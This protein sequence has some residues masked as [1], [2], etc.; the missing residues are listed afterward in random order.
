ML[1]VRGFDSGV[2]GSHVLLEDQRIGEVASA[3]R[4]AKRRRGTGRLSPMDAH[5]RLQIPLRRKRPTAELAT[6]RSL[7]GVGPVVHLKGATATEDPMADC[8]FVGVG[9]IAF[10]FLHQL[11]ELLRFGQVNFHEL[12]QGV[13]LL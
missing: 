4:A 12:F 9:H 11:V 3:D 2:V 13:V 10:T 5:V 8:A 6:I 7:S 1:L